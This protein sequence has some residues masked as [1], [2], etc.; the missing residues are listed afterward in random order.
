MPT[1][2]ERVDAVLGGRKPD[3]PPFSFWHH[4]PHD[5]VAGKPAVD[6]HLDQ[7]DRY[8][9][10]VLKVMN[11]NPYPHSGRIAGGRSRLARAAQG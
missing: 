6:A 10:D 5:Q 11:D 9:M 8:A 3:R 4:F 1:P 7:L 2:I